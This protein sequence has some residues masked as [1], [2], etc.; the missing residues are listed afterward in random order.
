MFQRIT[1]ANVGVTVERNN[2]T[3]TAAM[4]WMAS[5]T[6]RLEIRSERE[7]GVGGRRR[8][9]EKM[10]NVTPK[11]I[12]HRIIHTTHLF[13]AVPQFLLTAPSLPHLSPCLYSC[14]RRVHSS[15]AISSNTRTAFFVCLHSLL[16]KMLERAQAVFGSGWHLSTCT[17]CGG[18]CVRACGCWVS[19]TSLPSIHCHSFTHFLMRFPDEIQ[20]KNTN[21][22]TNTTKCT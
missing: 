13:S 16:C 11:Y 2:G 17:L 9:E 6:R 5:K 1:V 21:T 19:A 20:Y 14:A 10:C 18:L 12:I 8:R 7:R 3:A 22:R 4:H 15:L